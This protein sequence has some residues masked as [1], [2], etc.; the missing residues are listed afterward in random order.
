MSRGFKITVSL[1]KAT[2]EMPITFRL[3]LL[4]FLYFETIEDSKIFYL[5]FFVLFSK[6]CLVLFSR[7]S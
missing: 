4:F 7:L 3:F 5:F 2:K 1:E 6:F